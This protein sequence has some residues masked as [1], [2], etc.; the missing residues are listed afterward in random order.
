MIKKEK[1]FKKNHKKIKITK[2]WGVVACNE[3]KLRSQADV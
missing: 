2:E 1:Y 3:R